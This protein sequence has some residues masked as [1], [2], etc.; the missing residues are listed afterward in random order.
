MPYREFFQAATNQSGKPVYYTLKDDNVSP[1]DWWQQLELQWQEAFKA[2]V[3]KHANEP[4]PVELDFLC[5]LQ[6]IRLVGPTAPFPNLQVELTNLSGI[7]ALT[8][9]E[10][11]IVTHHKIVDID[12]LRD[13][14]HLKSLYLFNNSITSLEGIETLTQLERLYVHSNKISSIKPVEQLTNLQEFYINDNSIS[15][16]DGLTEKHSDKLLRFFCLPN[17]QLKQKEIIR[18]E[19][20]F[21]IICRKGA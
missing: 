14:P 2:A 1:L 9:L 7:K 4:N 16:L 19:R 3:L 13:L 5:N 18:A 21:G 12:V 15:S 17:E 10:I 11:V 8:K 20:E 6:T